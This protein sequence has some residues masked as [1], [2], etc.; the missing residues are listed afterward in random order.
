LLNS[1]YVAQEKKTLKYLGIKPEKIKLG[2]FDFTCCEGCQLQ[3]ANKENTLVDFLNLV[4]VVNFREISSDRGQDYEIALIEGSITRRDEEDRLRKIR[5]Q[6]KVLV[7]IGSCACFGGVNHLKNRFPIPDVVKEVY[8]KDTVET[9]KVRKVADVV[10][11]DLQIPGCPVSK[12]EVEKIVVNLV[13][14]AEITFPK[15]PV[16]V[17]CRRLLNTCVFDLGKM[18]LGPITRAGCGAVCPSGKVG[19]LG[20]RG[21]AEEANYESFRQILKE[22]G[23]SEKEVR[24]R[25]GFYNALPGMVDES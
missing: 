16:C 11:V 8:G 13:L 20:C 19:C 10:P 14:G 4:E 2:V 15:Y 18:C 21:P 1:N 17:E 6:A 12:E 22:H 5:E 3:L 7:A 23:F 9:L 24:E 25:A